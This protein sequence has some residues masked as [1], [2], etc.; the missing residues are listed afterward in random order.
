VS[1]AGIFHLIDGF[2]HGG[3]SVNCY[4]KHKQTPFGW[5]SPYVIVRKSRFVKAV[6]PAKSYL[7]KMAAANVPT[8]MNESR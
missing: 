6:I 3:T 2:G 5:C 8:M 7:K 4:K 1:H